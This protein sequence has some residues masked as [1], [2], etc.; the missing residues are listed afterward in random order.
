MDG[1]R[2]AVE[3]GRAKAV[4]VCNYDAAQLEEA[5]T[6][7]AKHNIPIASNQVLPFSCDHS[8]GLRLLAVPVCTVLS[9]RICAQ[10]LCLV[11]FV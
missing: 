3:S 7:L 9:L 6:L 11:S 8:P 2:D 1:L 5:C 10:S 4:G